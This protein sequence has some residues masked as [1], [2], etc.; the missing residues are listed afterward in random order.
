MLLTPIFKMNI[1]AKY[2]IQYAEHFY[3]GRI[4][5]S[6]VVFFQ[7]DVADWRVYSTG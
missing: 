1:D 4:M 6:W 3:K 5:G 2:I 7:F